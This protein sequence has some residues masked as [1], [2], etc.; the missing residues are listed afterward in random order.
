MT[1]TVKARHYG[2]ERGCRLPPHSLALARERIIVM[3][4]LEPS[5]RTVPVRAAGDHADIRGLATTVLVS[6]TAPASL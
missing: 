4:E 6:V 1:S 3:G 5:T 2:Q